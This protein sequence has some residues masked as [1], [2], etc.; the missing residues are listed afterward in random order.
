MKKVTKKGFANNFVLGEDFA[1]FE[2]K[3]KTQ[4]LE[5]NEI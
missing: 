5:L 2:F 4:F 1:D 3:L